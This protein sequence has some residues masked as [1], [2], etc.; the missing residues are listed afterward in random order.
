MPTDRLV[1]FVKE[2]A[3][4]AE[5]GSISK[6]EITGLELLQ[7][8]MKLDDKN[9]DHDSGVVIVSKE[10]EVVEA[11]TATATTPMT[12]QQQQLNHSKHSYN[13]LNDEEEEIV[14]IIDDDHNDNDNHGCPKEGYYISTLNRCM[15]SE[16]LLTLT[17]IFE[18]GGDDSHTHSH[19]NTQ[20]QY[21]HNNY[22]NNNETS[23]SFQ[24]KKRNSIGNNNSYNNN[25]IN[26][27][28][29]LINIRSI[30]NQSQSHKKNYSRRFSLDASVASSYANDSLMAHWKKNN[31]YSRRASLDSSVASS[32][33]NNSLMAHRKKSPNKNNIN[34]TFTQKTLP[35]VTASD[36]C[37]NSGR[38]ASLDSTVSSYA[39][40]SIKHHKTILFRNNNN[41]Q[42]STI[43]I[44]Q[45]HHQQQQQRVSCHRRASM[46][47]SECSSSIESYANDSV[48]LRKN[49]ITAKRGQTVTTT[50]QQQLPF[51]HYCNNDNDDDSSCVSSYANDSI[52][53]RM[54]TFNKN[55]STATNS[56][57]IQQTT[58]QSNNSNITRNGK[59]IKN[60]ILATTVTTP[61]TDNTAKAPR[62]NS[63]HIDH[64][65]NY[66]N[67][68]TTTHHHCE[69][70]SPTSSH[71]NDLSSSSL[72]PRSHSPTVSNYKT[73]SEDEDDNNNDSNGSIISCDQQQQQQQQHTITVVDNYTQKER[74]QSIPSQEQKDPD[75]Q[76]T[77]SSERQSEYDTIRSIAQQH[78][79][80]RESFRLQ[81]QSNPAA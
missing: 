58:I 40:D 1:A 25:N 37:T 76:R 17:S 12:K 45:H 15:S 67:S 70:L 52:Q 78:A 38:R 11:A 42:P 14:E 51:D 19:N 57:T 35:I 16:S 68:K 53:L 31:N 47:Y 46:D 18:R 29:A 48:E 75:Q 8:Q 23:Y 36:Y 44:K 72:V 50:K 28:N 43:G 30:A 54:R 74:A 65:N 5:I 73:G 56:N 64:N 80:E 41:H 49:E 10:V 7:Q 39:N 13:Y 2:E 24:Q 4:A 71:I 34:T 81:L 55:I 20:H 60:N 59:S 32:Y 21:H 33:A 9:D 61:T 3:G 77:Q 79:W 27:T 69:L 26:V 62:T 66:S 6:V 63:S 22:H